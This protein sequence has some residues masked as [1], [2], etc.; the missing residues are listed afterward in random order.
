VGGDTKCSE[1]MHA[2]AR[3][4]QK[5]AGCLEAAALSTAAR[6]DIEAEQSEGGGGSHPPAPC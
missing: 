2:A 5:S 3:L 1:I 6:S 4:L